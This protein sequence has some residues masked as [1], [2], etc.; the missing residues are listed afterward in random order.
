VLAALRDPALD[1]ALGTGIVRLRH[2]FTER[3][4]LQLDRLVEIAPRLP[5]SWIFANVAQ[6]SPFEGRG[7]EEPVDCTHVADF[8]RDLTTSDTSI[9]IY[10]VERTAEYADLAREIEPIVRDLVGE[11]EGGL[12]AINLGLFAAS[13]RSV[14]PAHPDRHHNLLFELRGRKQ[15]WLEEDL[16]SRDHH[17]RVLDYLRCPPA[18]VTSL[19]RAQSFVLEPGDGVYIPPYTFHWTELFDE[20]GL[21]FSIGFSTPATTADSQAHEFDLRMRRLHLR[22]RP[23]PA[24]SWRGRAKARLGAWALQR[25][26]RKVESRVTV[27]PS[28]GGQA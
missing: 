6:H 11:R 21:A 26:A 1:T 18:G 17:V 14:T 13:P 10:N 28:S 27:S 25:S 20:P 12:S 4:D 7:C 15:I 5:M 16:V 23:A 19:P 24:L 8:L 3:D 22:P 9:R 2:D